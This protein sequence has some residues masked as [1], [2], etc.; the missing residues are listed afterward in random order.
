MKKLA[1][2]M[3]LGV[4][5]TSFVIADEDMSETSKIIRQNPLKVRMPSKSTADHS[6]HEALQKLFKT[7]PDVTEACLSCH[8]EAAQQLM[9]TK[10][11]TWVCP[12]KQSKE[13]KVYIINNFCIALLS[14]EPRC[15]SCHAGYGWK[16]KNFDF[17]N[18]K[19]VDCLVCHEQTGTYVKFP[20]GAGHPT[21]VETVF[22]GKTYYPPDFNKIAQSVGKPTRKNCGACHYYGG[23][24]DGVK[25]GDMD[26]SLQNSERG[27]DVH[28]NLKGENFDCIECHRTLD[29][30]IAGGCSS[31]LPENDT[32]KSPMITCESCHTDAPHRTE[33]TVFANKLNDHTDV[34]SCQACHID[35]FAKEK[36]TKMFWDWSK[37]GQKDENGKPFTKK[38]ADGNVIYDS[39]KGAFIWKKKVMPEY[40]WWNGDISVTTGTDKIDPSS[41]VIINKVVGSYADGKSKIHPF[42]VHR[43]VQPFDPV[44]NTLVIPKLFG[45]KGS[46]AYWAEFDW[47]KAVKAGMEYADLPFSGEVGF[48]ETEMYW[49]QYHMV[50][51]KENALSCEECHSKEGRLAGLNGFFLPSR[52]K[53]GIIDILG[54]FGIA[55]AFCGVIIHTGMRVRKNKDKKPAKP[56]KKSSK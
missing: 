30:K 25:H 7:G 37:A 43:G 34:V 45:P 42:K 13:G 14:N 31:R 6:K 49:P 56:K 10:H 47:N 22:M 21:Y 32:Y 1:I 18:E 54:W 35:R 27:L 48:I 15:T 9:K 33:D 50:S 51:P 8:T 19:N 38:D 29:H 4:I 17:D 39:K 23:G 12:K 20:T 2:L 41:K 52:D 26:A 40:Y 36:P 3:V 28:M 55:G 44:N 24:G 16:D 5:F 11:W 53:A 46:G